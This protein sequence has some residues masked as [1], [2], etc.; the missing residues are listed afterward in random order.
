MGSAGQAPPP[1]TVDETARRARSG[2]VRRAFMRPRRGM[3]KVHRWLAI[4][5]MAWLVVIGLTGAW[6]AER[7]QLD[8]WLDPGRYDTTEGD[9]GAQAAVDAAAEELPEGAH[10]YGLAM[11]GNARGV[12][13]VWAERETPAA[14]KGGEPTYDY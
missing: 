11:P 5:L 4:G 3:V 14:T 1:G 6:L 13:K 7:H 12:Y 8:A 2:R 10:P 9:V